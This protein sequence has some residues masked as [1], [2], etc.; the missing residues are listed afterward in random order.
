MS[1]KQIFDTTSRWVNIYQLNDVVN[2]IYTTIENT[3]QNPAK[4]QWG[5]PVQNK[6]D[7]PLNKKV[8]YVA[9]VIS[10]LK[11]YVYNGI[12]YVPVNAD[13]EFA[14]LEDINEMFNNK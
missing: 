6:V 14:T 12:E 13:L 3:T 7:L 1:N 4:I 5:D 10:E 8:G 2:N 11:L 9:L